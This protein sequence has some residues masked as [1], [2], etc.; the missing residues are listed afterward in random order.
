LDKLPD[1]TNLEKLQKLYL[2]CCP[3]TVEIKSRLESLET[4]WI[5]SCKSFRKLPDPSSHK[6]LNSLLI[7]KCEK[8]EDSLGYDDRWRTLKAE[9]Q[10]DLVESDLSE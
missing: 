1:L 6:K 7:H 5:G 9:T 2:Q 8:V 10:S 4:V 3:K